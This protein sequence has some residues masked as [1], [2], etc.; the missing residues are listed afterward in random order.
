MRG[1]EGQQCPARGSIGQHGQVGGLGL[2]F[3]RVCVV[4]KGGGAGT[5]VGR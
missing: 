2:R 4:M 3:L 1:S 5:G